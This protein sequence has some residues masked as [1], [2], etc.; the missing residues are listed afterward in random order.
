MFAPNYKSSYSNIAFILLGFI[1]EQVAGK[2]YQDLLS[3]SILDPLGMNHT[4]V[5][6]PNSSMGVI[7]ATYNDWAYVA[8]AYDPYDDST[9]SIDFALLMNEIIEPVVFIPHPAISPSFSA[10]Y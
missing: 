5:R 2:S 6:R 3:S 8:G 4:T 9:K 7:P 1:L 10:R